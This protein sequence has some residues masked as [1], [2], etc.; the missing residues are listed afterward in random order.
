MMRTGIVGLFIWL[1]ACSGVDS[2]GRSSQTPSSPASIPTSTASI[3]GFVLGA[4]VGADPYAWGDIRG[5][6]SNSRETIDAIAADMEAGERHGLKVVIQGSGD[7]YVIPQD[8]DVGRLT[9]NTVIPLWEEIA[10][11]FRSHP[12]LLAYCPVEEI[13]DLE[14]GAG[15]GTLLRVG[16]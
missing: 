11:R 10:T 5:M 1:T 2:S 13:G 8:P 3:D 16:S 6:G 9:R 12:A 15:A 14:L 4:W 7:P